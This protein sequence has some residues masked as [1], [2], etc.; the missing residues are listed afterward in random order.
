[1]QALSKIKNLISYLTSANMTEP[2]HAIIWAVL[3]VTLKVFKVLKLNV[4]FSHLKIAFLKFLNLIVC[5]S[6]LKIT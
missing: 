6:H 4:C 3:V 2:G 5:F 1:M